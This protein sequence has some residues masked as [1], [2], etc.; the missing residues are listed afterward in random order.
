MRVPRQGRLVR[1]PLQRGSDRAETVMLVAAFLAVAPFAANGRKLGPCHLRPGGASPAGRAL[2]GPGHAPAGA[3]ICDGLPGCRVRPPRRR[4]TLAGA[5]RAGTDRPLVRSVRHDR[6][7]YGAGVGRPGRPTNQFSARASPAGHP[8]LS[9]R[10]GGRRYPRHRPDRGGPTSPLDPGSPPDGRVGRR[11]AGHRTAVD[12]AT[13]ATDQEGP[14]LGVPQSIQPDF[15][16]P[17]A[18]TA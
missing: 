6:G 7:Q 16:G 2:P 8:G 10:R 17:L 5:D 12:F 18:G 14:R 3:V 4:R 15:T 11:L 13:V 1:N 9:G